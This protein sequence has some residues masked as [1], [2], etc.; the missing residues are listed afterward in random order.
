[1]HVVILAGGEGARLWPFSRKEHPKQFLSF[2]DRF[3]L[4]QKTILRFS[5]LSFVRSISI[6]TTQ[7]YLLLVEEELEKLGL[8]GNV[9]LIIEPERKNTAPAIAYS[10]KWLQEKKGLT[11]DEKILILPSDHWIEPQALFTSYLEAIDASFPKKELLL[12]GIRP[13]RAETGY[14]YIQIGERKNLLSYEVKAF[15]EKPSSEKAQDYLR[16][17]DYYWNSG[18]FTATLGWFLKAF[19]EKASIISSFLDKSLE[20][21]EKSF[22]QMP[23]ISFDYAIL[24][25]SKEVVVCP[26]A[27]SW[28]DIGSWDGLYEVMHKDAEENV[29]LGQIQ[30]IDTKRSLILAGKKKISTIGVED[31]LIVETEDALLIT[32]RGASQRVKELLELPVGCQ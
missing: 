3:T 4:L 11:S 17:G 32:K 24:E 8:K 30:A 9:D 5:F 13:T 25:K 18:I 26:L 23:N 2:G 28:S 7:A 12:F 6:V 1:M 19:Q 10:L 20:E 22:G 15:I 14:G 29:F 16:L 21:V 27:I 31:L